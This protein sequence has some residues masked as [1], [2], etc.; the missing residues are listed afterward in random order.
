MV[1]PL[2]FL[3]A[4]AL[5]CKVNHS[6]HGSALI[7]TNPDDASFF[8]VA[9]VGLT[10]KVAL[11][12]LRRAGRTRVQLSSGRESGVESSSDQASLILRS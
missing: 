5:R 6:P 4:F 11:T 1:L 12:R 9:A 2:L 3:V 8:R 7:S 10:E